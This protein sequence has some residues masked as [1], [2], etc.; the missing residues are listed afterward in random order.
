[1]AMKL[2]EHMALDPSQKYHPL[3]ETMIEVAKQLVKLENRIDAVEKCIQDIDDRI[4][5]LECPQYDN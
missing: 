1:M 4:L 3:T 5:R 2:S